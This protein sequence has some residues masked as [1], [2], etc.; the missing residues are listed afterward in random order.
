[1]LTLCKLWLLFGA[2]LAATIDDQRDQ[3]LILPNQVNQ[4]TPF[5]IKADNKDPPDTILILDIECPAI[6]SV[7]IRDGEGVNVCPKTS[8]SGSLAEVNKL[9]S[10]LSYSIS[11]AIATKFTVKYSLKQISEG[12]IITQSKFA[13]TC[14]I[15]TEIPIKVYEPEIKLTTGTGSVEYLVLSID[16]EYFAKTD[17]SYLAIVFDKKP[18]WVDST[19]VGADYYV[20]IQTNTSS[21]SDRKLKLFIKDSKSGL[22]TKSV[23][24]GIDFLDIDAKSAAKNGSQYYFLA[25]LVIFGLV[26]IALIFVIYFAN[27]KVSCRE[28]LQESIDGPKRANTMITTNC[29]SFEDKSTVLTDSIINWNKQLVERH[30]TKCPNILDNSGVQEKSRLHAI[31]MVQSY[32]RFDESDHA[33]EFAREVDHEDFEDISEIHQDSPSVKSQE[34]NQKSLFLEEFKF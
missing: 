15:A 22:K 17:P 18:E 30:R 33:E 23:A 34:F 32:G 26:I 12:Q 8:K 2:T 28:N 14:Q 16:Q 29:Q 24:F 11:E 19:F 3:I 20:K 1:M 25:F 9:I 4:L 5:T 27:Q 6:E 10:A 13:Q 7:A 21:L 31:D